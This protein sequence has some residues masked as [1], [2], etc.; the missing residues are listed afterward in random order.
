MECEVSNHERKSLLQFAKL[1]SH[2][3]R[4]TLSAREE[5]GVRTQINYWSAVSMRSA[6]CAADML[7]VFDNVVQSLGASL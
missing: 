4:C 7:E 3:L 6:V 1:F 5:C 2:W